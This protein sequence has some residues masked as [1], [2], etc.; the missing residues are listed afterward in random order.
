MPIE[1]YRQ[2]KPARA[3]ARWRESG[4]FGGSRPYYGWCALR[5]VELL[6]SK[7]EL[8]RMIAMCFQDWKVG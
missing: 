7:P 8:I 6:R 3:E 2:V 5:R 1:T 4:G